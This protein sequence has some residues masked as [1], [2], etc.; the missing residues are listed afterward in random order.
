MNDRPTKSADYIAV[1]EA[2]DNCEGDISDEVT[3]LV[4]VKLRITPS[5]NTP[6]RGERIRIKGSVRPQHD[7]TKMI[8]QRKKNGR[9]VRFKVDTLNRRSFANYVF[10]ARFN[11][12]VFR[13]KWR[14]QDDDHVG[15][16]SRQ[17]TIRTR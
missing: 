7:G 17:I 15:N 6:D 8:L 10:R 1:V 3:V 12:A 14:S 9:F 4:R 16:T 13:V 11:R 2:E 5:E